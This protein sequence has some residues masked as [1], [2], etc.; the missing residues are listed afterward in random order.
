MEDHAPTHAA[1]ASGGASGHEAPRPPARGEDHESPARASS[2]PHGA[3]GVRATEGRENERQVADDFLA[4][5]E[6]ELKKE[7]VGRG[8]EAILIKE[9]CKALAEHLPTS[10]QWL[11]MGLEHPTLSAACE[12]RGI[13]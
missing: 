5:L 4:G 1:V 9:G 6:A 10:L 8:E 2:E 13:R 12:E 11:G 3:A 7:E